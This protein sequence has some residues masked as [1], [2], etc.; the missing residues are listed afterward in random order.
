MC[1]CDSGEDAVDDGYNPHMQ[2]LPVMNLYL[3]GTTPTSS[4]NVF[5]GPLICSRRCKCSFANL[6][7]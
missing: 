6:L 1:N 4:I 3:G 7:H 2:L 5:I